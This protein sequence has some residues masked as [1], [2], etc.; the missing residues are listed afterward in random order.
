M[1]DPFSS[2]RNETSLVTGATGFI[3]SHVA[4]RLAA[5]GGRV[6]GLARSAAKGAWLAERGI[7]IVEG[8][9]T[10]PDSLRRAA[11]DCRIVFSIAGWVGQPNSFEAARQVGLDGTRAL[12]EAALDAG[13]RCLVHTSSIA[14]YGPMAE[15][16]IDETW[17]LRATDAYGATKAQ[18]EALALSY[19][20]RL[21]ISV[22]R[23]AQV[24]GPRGATWTTL[25]F[26]AVKRSI[27]ILVDGGRGTFHPCYIDN[28]VDA[29]LLAATRPE[30]AGE[31]FTLVDDVTTWRE[32]V[33]CY[34]R[35]IGRPARSV[36]SVFLRLATALLVG[37]AKL[38]RRPPLGTPESI[39]FLT[40]SC[41]YSNAKA[42]RL[43]GWS[44]RVSLD[45]GMRRT[46]T[47][48]RESGRLT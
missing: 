43:L 6:R 9:L 41:R 1:D 48:L 13:A 19:A 47:W 25:L 31:A 46:E 22:I 8:D 16:V 27:P 17:P 37:R 11:R 28:L 5:L 21:A 7:E 10:D 38:I 35:M 45:E 42:Q 24:Y 33:G 39:K 15:G 20:D 36:P 18:S 23:P 30:A 2:L 3:G 26:D 44:P 14:A 40:G 32:F 4:E 12:V 34:A 29:Y